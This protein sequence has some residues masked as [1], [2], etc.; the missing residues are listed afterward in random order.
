LDALFRQGGGELPMPISLALLTDKSGGQSPPTQ[1]RNALAQTLAAQQSELRTITRSQGYYGAVERLQLS[2]AALDHLIAS[3]Q[4]QPGIKLVI[5]LGPGWP[6]LSGPNVQLTTKDRDQLFQMVVKLST[7]MREARI[8]ICNVDPVGAGGSLTRESYYEDFLKGVASANR[9]QNGDLGLQVLAVQSGGRVL[10]TSSD[11][12][13]SINRCL[14]DRKAFYVLTF[15]SPPADRPNE[16]HTL[17]IKIGK[18]R[19][20]ARTRAGYYAQP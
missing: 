13:D 2:I 15:D 1:D 11:E 12:A 4:T 9:V 20:T 14:A 18:P 19:L 3:L 8:E 16:Y 7:E 17:Q 10:N 6:L 5:W